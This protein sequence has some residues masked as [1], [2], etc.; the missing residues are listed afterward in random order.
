MKILFRIFLA[1]FLCTTSVLCQQAKIKPGDIIEIMVVGQEAM[2]QSVIVKPDGTVDY[3]GLQ[4][5]PIDGITLQR[6]QEILIAQLSRYLETTPLVFTRFGDSYLIKVTILGQVLAP[7][8]YPIASTATIQGAIS[9]AGGIIQGAQ[10]SNV[11]IIRMEDQE[12]REINVNMEKFYLHGDPTTL[13]ALK[14][15]DTII[16]SGNPL[17]TKVK[18]IGSVQNPGNYDV[19]LKNTILDVIFMAGGPTDDANLK[20][21]KIISLNTQTPREFNLNYDDLLNSDNLRKTPIVIPGD[22]VFVPKRTFTWRKFFNV[23]RD[24]TAFATLYYLISRSQE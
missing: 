7:G 2:S 11:K 13:P 3:P 16:V 8:L 24:L 17:A 18:V 15:G 19:F 9:A 10:L 14:E 5:L 12:R 23:L 6:L 20:K 1:I 4:G 21:V 22:V